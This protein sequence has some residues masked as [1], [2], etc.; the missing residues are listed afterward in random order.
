M[1]GSLAPNLCVILVGSRVLLR[2]GLAR[3]LSAADFNVVATAPSVDDIAADALPHDQSILLVLDVCEDEFSTIR[4]ISA[5]KQ[6]YPAARIALLDDHG[7]LADGNLVAAFE[8]GAHAYFTEPTCTTFIKSLELVMLGEV[9][10]PPAIMSML[11]HRHNEV[12]GSRFASGAG[13]SR[14]GEGEYTP[15]LSAREICILRRLIAGESNK[16]I[17]RN[18]AIAEATVKV[19]VKAILRKIRVN[20]RT[21]AAIW[22][23]LNDRLVQ[24]MSKALTVGAAVPAEPSVSRNV[25]ISR[26]DGSAIEV[27]AGTAGAQHPRAAN[28]AEVEPHGDGATLGMRC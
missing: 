12:A 21:Q 27:G 26:S 23:M 7:R 22:G 18:N 10:V 25:V 5:F 2:E 3:I 17:A 19:H 16:T 14:A 20:N 8:A 9:I 6:R 24:D 13:G 1:Q 28:G 11:G 4:Q 15:R